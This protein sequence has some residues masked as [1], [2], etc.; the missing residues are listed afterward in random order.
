LNNRRAFT[1]NELVVVIAIIGVL[2]ALLLPAAQKAR[3]SAN[4]TTCANNLKQLGIALH[5]YEGATRKF[6]NEDDWNPTST[7]ST[8][9]A[10]LLPYV[11]QDNQIPTWRTNPQPV[12]VFLCPSRRTTAVGPQDDHAP[13]HHFSF[14]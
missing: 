14:V 1:L 12:K 2:I 9:Y 3:E 4:R 8:L 5:N 6:P 11:E 7:V 13:E 10:A